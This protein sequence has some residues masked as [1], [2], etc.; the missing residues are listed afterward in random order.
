MFATESVPT[1]WNAIFSEKD[2]LIGGRLFGFFK[3]KGYADSVAIQWM[4]MALYKGKYHGLRYSEEQERQLQKAL[5]LTPQ[6]TA[7]TPTL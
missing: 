6:A 2:K 1:T 4:N 3:K 7:S 5:T